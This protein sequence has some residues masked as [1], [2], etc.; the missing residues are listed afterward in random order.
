M[1]E[2]KFIE[3]MEKIREIKIMHADYSRKYHSSKSSAIELARKMWGSITTYRYEPLSISPDKY[4]NTMLSAIISERFLLRLHRN[5]WKHITISI[6]GLGGSGKTTYSII[7]AMGALKL[8]GY[9]ERQILDAISGL[10]FFSAKE[11]VEFSKSLIEK[12]EWV[13]F[14]ILDDIGS[15]ISKYWIFLGQYFWS[16]LFS[17]LDQLKDWTGCLILTAR[18]FESIPARLRELSDMVIEARE[19]DFQGVILDI[20]SYYMYDDYVSKRRRR[21][22]L[23]FIDVLLPTIKMPDVMWKRMLETRRRT[24]LERLKMVAMALELQP[25][26]ELV[27]ILRM[28]KQVVKREHKTNNSR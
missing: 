7:S 15:Q 25:K 4:M 8:I 23:K 28:R 27:R 14:I 2:S 17:V 11:F 21:Q 16:Y 13:P 10:T 12:R 19:I 1:E 20:F 22:G 6:V 24:G 5:L 26:L 18:T 9:P 3:L